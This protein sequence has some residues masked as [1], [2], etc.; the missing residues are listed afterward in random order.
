MEGF[1]KKNQLKEQELYKDE[2]GSKAKEMIS[3][4]EIISR[5]KNYFWKG[6]LDRKKY[7]P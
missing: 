6:I 2:E 1:H 5:L 3:L 4:G 7:V